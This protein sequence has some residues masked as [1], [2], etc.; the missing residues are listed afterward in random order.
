MGCKSLQLYVQYSQICLHTYFT[1]CTPMVCQSCRWSGGCRETLELVKPCIT[2]HRVS[3]LMRYRVRSQ[4][5]VSA[6]AFHH[7][8]INFRA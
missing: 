7:C 5:A 6:G 2:R 4:L 8:C 3:S 1:S